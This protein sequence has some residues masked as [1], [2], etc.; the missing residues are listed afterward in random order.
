MPHITTSYEEGN[1][2]F[3]IAVGRKETQCGAYKTS[4]IKSM[5]PVR[6]PE[7]SDYFLIIL[8]CFSILSDW[9]H[10]RVKMDIVRPQYT[11]LNI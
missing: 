10:L 7:G 6:G 5:S 1:I 4:F 9:N 8:R 3:H 11:Q 2:S